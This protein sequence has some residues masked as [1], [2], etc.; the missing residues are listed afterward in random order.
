MED[1]KY[2]QL[3]FTV[4]FALDKPDEVKV[5]E[6]VK[7]LKQGKARSSA[8]KKI[9][10]D[11]YLS[12]GAPDLF[13]P[14]P[15]NDSSIEKRVEIL[16]KLINE[17]VKQQKEVQKE[18]TDLKNGANELKKP[19]NESLRFEGTEIRGTENKPLKTENTRSDFERDVEI[20]KNTEKNEI[21]NPNIINQ[22]ENDFKIEYDNN[23]SE[24]VVDF[25]DSIN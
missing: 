11:H 9:L 25:L 7:T 17:L 19:N 15:S 20:L 1:K 21:R 24:S 8:I 18:K 10:M 12:A 6:L 4:T 2:S 22:E 23:I 13:E 5:L 16:E 14:T 3:K